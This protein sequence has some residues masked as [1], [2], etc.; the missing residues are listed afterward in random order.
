MNEGFTNVRQTGILFGSMVL[1]LHWIK[2][3]KHSI[4]IQCIKFQSQP[5]Y[6]DL[7]EAWGNLILRCI[8]RVYFQL[9]SIQ[10][11]H[12]QLGTFHDSFITQPYTSPQLIAE[13]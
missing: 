11:A 10:G 5:K 2:I 7:T 8:C 4:S 12:P 1:S 9:S 6:S 3:S 13:M